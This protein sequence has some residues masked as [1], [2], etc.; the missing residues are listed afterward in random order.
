MVV[1][2]AAGSLTTPPC[3]ETVDWLVWEQPIPVTNKQVSSICVLSHP[4]A[5]MAS[6]AVYKLLF[7]PVLI[8]VARV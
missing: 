1:S 3:S 2:V 6:V 4:S 5:C 8:A 7:K